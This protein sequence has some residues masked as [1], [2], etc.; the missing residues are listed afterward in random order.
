[1]KAIFAM[2]AQAHRSLG[3]YFSMAMPHPVSDTMESAESEET[4][5]SGDGSQHEPLGQVEQQAEVVE[6][7]S[8]LELPK[9]STPRQR[10]LRREH[11]VDPHQVTDIMDARG[12]QS[13]SSELFTI[14]R[15]LARLA[16][17]NCETFRKLFDGKRSFLPDREIS[18]GSACTGSA[19]EVAVAHAFQNAIQGDNAT[20]FRVRISF[21]CEIREE[22]RKWIKGVHEAF[23]LDEVAASHRGDKGAYGQG[24]RRASGQRLQGASGRPCIFKDIADLGGATAHCVVHGACCP[25]PKCSIFVCCTSCKD[26]SRLISKRG[27]VLS[28]QRGESNGEAAQTFHGMLGYL[29]S[30]RPPI[31]IFENVDTM[32]DVVG[33]GDLDKVSN[34]EI[35]LAEFS[36][37]GYECQVMFAESSMFG[38]PQKRRRVYIIAVLVVANNQLDFSKR[39]VLDT[40][41]TLRSLIKVC[42]RTAPCAF[43]VLYPDT[44]ACPK[45][46]G[47]TITREES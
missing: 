44:H 21:S 30:T 7:N 31:V 20:S 2:Y 41:A 40:F 29:D 3:V 38:V 1:M 9:K 25:V 47:K 10:Q 22:K 39:S 23:V 33:D 18:I 15:L 32:D 12:F 5:P 37:R 42:Q 26:F 43:D 46:T 14:G 16:E 4:V 28:S 8:L 36:S 13:V 6:E 11:T 35:A 19:C 17:E 24:N 27:P 45:I 34:L